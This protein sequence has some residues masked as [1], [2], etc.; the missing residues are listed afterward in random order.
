MA[1]WTTDV[2]YLFG[3]QFSGL[4]TLGG[5]VRQDV[6]CPGRFCGVGTAKNQYQRGG[7]TVP[8]KFPYQNLDLRFRKDFPNFGGTS[9][10]VTADLFNA[11]NNSNFGCYNTGDRSAPNFG[12]ASCVISDARRLQ[13]GLEYNF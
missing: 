3:I 10:G 1:N 8:G 5:R 12:T 2:P 7:F 9:L 11:T 4:L 13:L 6:G